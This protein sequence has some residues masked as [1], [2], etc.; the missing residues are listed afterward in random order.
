M[1]CAQP[2]QFFCS[3]GGIKFHEPSPHQPVQQQPI[4][5]QPVHQQPAHQQPVHQQPVQPPAGAPSG[6][7]GM[8]GDTPKARG[9]PPPGRRHSNIHVNMQEEREHMRHHVKEDFMDPEE[10]LDDNQL[11]MQYFRKHDMDGNNKL[12]GV[13]L[14]KALTKMNEEDHDHD[15]EEEKSG[16]EGEGEKKEETEKK[17]DGSPKFSIEEVIPII[18]SILEQDD[19]D[20][21]GY[22]TWPEFL[23]RQ[24]QHKQN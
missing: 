3:D 21:D 14:L 16:E 8:P 10:K 6:V 7:T 5:Q 22:I 15:H 17:D 23:S 20:N 2:N 18:D 12:D 11:L 19:L 13:E 9:P 1:H 24:A 4:H